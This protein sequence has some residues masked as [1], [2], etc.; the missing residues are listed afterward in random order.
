MDR[1]PTGMLER[2][3]SAEC[4]DTLPGLF[5]ERV[6]RTPLSVAY[7][8]YD[9]RAGCWINYSWASMEIRAARFQQALTREGLKTGDRVALCLPIVPTGSALTWRPSVS[10]S[11]WSRSM[12]TTA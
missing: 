10:A 7:R 12:Q 1:P 9:P 8:E 4:A 5:H 3:I 2:L 6:R 11:S